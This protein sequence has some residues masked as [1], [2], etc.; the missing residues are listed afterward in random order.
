MLA[1][2]RNFVVL[3]QLQGE[4]RIDAIAIFGH[5][6]DRVPKR[7]LMDDQKTE[8]ANV[9]EF[10]LVRHPQ[11]ESFASRRARAVFQQKDHRPGGK[12]LLGVAYHRSRQAGVSQQRDDIEMK[13][14]RHLEIACQSCCPNEF[15]A[16]V[17]N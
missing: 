12:H 14:L 11:S 10:T 15:H 2:E 6:S 8:Q 16:Y 7:W 4:R 3:L 1:Q 5:D 9:G 13:V 17:A